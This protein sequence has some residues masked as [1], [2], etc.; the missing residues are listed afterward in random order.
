MSTQTYVV[1]YNIYEKQL[2]CESRGEVVDS[3]NILK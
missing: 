2:H 3:I 1:P